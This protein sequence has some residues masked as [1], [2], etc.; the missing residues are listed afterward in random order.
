MLHNTKDLKNLAIQATDGEI[1][2]VKDLYFDDDAWVLRY[3][4]V[5]TGS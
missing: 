2:K 5:E 1:G 3:F 4:V